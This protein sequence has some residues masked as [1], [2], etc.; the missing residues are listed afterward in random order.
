M[1][2]DDAPRNE[3][4]GTGMADGGTTDG[5]EMGAVAPVGAPARVVAVTGASGGI[6][7]ALVRAL[8]EHGAVV[9]GLTRTEAG[10]ASLRE[11]GADPVVGDL[12]GPDGDATALET[13]C[14]GAQVVFHLAAW[15][16]G[17]G[18]RARADS[19][20][21]EGTRRVVRAAEGAGARRVV[22]ASSV[23]V[24]GPVRSGNV[25][26]TREPWQV[27]DPYGDSKIAAERAAHDAATTVEVVILRPTM[28][29]GPGTNSWTLT[30]VRAL[31]RGLPM[32]FGDGEALLDAVYVDDVAR[33]FV[34][35]GEADGVAGRAF[36]VTG[37]TTTWNAFFGA[38]AA[39]LGTRLRR[40][41]LGPVRF[42]AN[43]AAAVTRALPG[44]PDVVP[45]MIGVMTST[46][47][48]DGSAAREAL[49]YGPEVDLASGMA[50]TAHWL[51]AN[52]HAPGPRTAMVVGAAR[53]LGL[54]VA[55]ELRRRYVR[56]VAADVDAA[57]LAALR[58]EGF[59]TARADVRDEAS[60]A[61]AVA[62]AEALGDDLDAVVTTVGMLRPG[63]LEAQAAAEL[64]LQLELNALGPVRVARAA[65]PGMR[66]RGR[67]R[68]VQVGST[69]GFLVTPFMG[70]YS[71]GKYALEGF[72]DALRQE[73]APFGVEVVL[74]QPGAMRTGFADAAK[75]GLR[76]EAERVGEPWAPYLMRLH[77][78]DLWGERNAAE[79]AS[80]ARVVASAV[81][82]PRA[83]ARKRATADVPFVKL[84][85]GMPDRLKDAYFAR[86]LGL[87]RPRRRRR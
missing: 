17:A 7:R 32:V 34:A 30:P 80:V 18:G 11:L 76:R 58:D 13:L 49:G 65:A 63:A 62:D 31:A 87:G 42:G 79:P 38:Y 1:N 9:R 36:N 54:E 81:M 20:N 56:V 66:R 19:V 44:V 83:P 86:P 33:A 73:L 46:A 70:A 5:G 82:S 28:V 40:L 12:A 37:A 2:G 57:A 39:M 61:R 35:A 67:G 72:S 15:M 24:Y 22:I 16:G 85:A 25:D 14:R 4:P 6:G 52:G 53:G 84:F 45:E 29:Y 68:L 75:E 64:E 78:S 69:N 23:A 71:A 41:P 21:V 77:D 3:L 59:T 48:F 74:V 43:V 51:R 55:R 27:G 60:L 50:H 47:T 10:A 8:V 26:E